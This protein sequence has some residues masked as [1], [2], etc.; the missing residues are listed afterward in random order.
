M[1]SCAS[2][3]LDL[4]PHI[5]LPRRAVLQDD[6]YMYLIIDETV[7]SSLSDLRADSRR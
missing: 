3:D 7:R 4:L 5:S 2:A 1:Y 6:N